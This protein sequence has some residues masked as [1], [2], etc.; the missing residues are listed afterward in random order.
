ML[1]M[2]NS[3]K[4][5]KMSKQVNVQVNVQSSQLT[6]CITYISQELCSIRTLFC[7]CVQD[8]SSSILSS[9]VTSLGEGLILLQHFCVWTGN[10]VVYLHMGIAASHYS[11]N[12]LEAMPSCFYYNFQIY[13]SITSALHILVK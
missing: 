10:R 6:H 13:R 3:Q 11:I 12:S 2:T 8:F 9:D 4:K 7:I 1:P 5:M